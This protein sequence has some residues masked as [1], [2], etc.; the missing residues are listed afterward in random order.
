[1]RIG[2]TGHRPNRLYGYDLTDSRWILLKN[3]LKELL[4]ENSCN[5]AISGMALDLKEQGY[6]IKLHAI[7]PCINQDGMWSSQYKE[8]YKNILS[9]A[10]KVKY[11]SKRA[12]HPNCIQKRNEYIV[13]NCDLLIAV[14]DGIKSGGT[15][16]C[17]HYA[18]ETG[19][20]IL[21]V[22]PNKYKK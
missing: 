12:Y 19:K 8:L 10:D 17:I 1:M 18:Y 14:W 15:Y 13:D 16:R 21:I 5:I 9:K 20:E 3:Q 7:L 22:S 6:G 11:I 2:I 4:I